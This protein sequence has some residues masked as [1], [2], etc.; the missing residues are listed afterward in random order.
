MHVNLT[1]REP[2]FA[3]DR[4]AASAFLAEALLR[5]KQDNL[6][7]PAGRQ[8]GNGWTLAP[9][10]DLETLFRDDLGGWCRTAFSRAWSRQRLAPD[11]VREPREAAV[12]GLRRAA[13]L[14]DNSRGTG[15]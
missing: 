15:L 11:G 13:G 12:P 4:D 7:W 14:W 1:R 5:W 10:W 2:Q 8:Y 9:G 6:T 3:L